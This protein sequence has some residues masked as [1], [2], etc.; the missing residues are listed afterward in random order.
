MNSLAALAKSLINL[1][2]PLH[3]ASCGRHIE[4][5]NEH[6]ACDFCLKQIKRN[7]L[8]YCPS[9]GRA[10]SGHFSE[11]PDHPMSPAQEI[12]EPE[13]VCPEC[14]KIRPYFSSAY[15]A[16]LYEGSLKELIHKFK[17]DNRRTLSGIFTAIML[18]FIKDNPGII[19]GIDAI[20]FVPLHKKRA[21]VR[22][23]NQSELLAR[24]IGTKLGIPV[25]GCLEKTRAT[26]NQNELSRE[27]RLV[28]LEGAFRISAKIKPDAVK[29]AGMLIIDDVMTTGT[30]LNETSRALM[31]CGAKSVR[32]LT[33]ARGI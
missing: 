2:Y 10:W 25:I 20:T 5:V 19:K 31:G 17:Y 33:L 12:Q 7:P 15:S 4:S 29:G 13:N 22:A 24:L 3:C 18:D 32:C 21:L 28:N 6:G 26:R 30:T 27:D 14:R 11:M 1:I 16:C 9:C 8:P 23:F